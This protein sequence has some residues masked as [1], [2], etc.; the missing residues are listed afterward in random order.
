MFPLELPKFVFSL[1]STLVPRFTEKDQVKTY[2]VFI[3]SDV[4]SN[5]KSFNTVFPKV[6]VKVV[7]V[8]VV[9]QVDLSI[10]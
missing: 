1:Q 4:I 7:K 3:T 9:L 6:Y 8:V 10:R 5:T 2:S